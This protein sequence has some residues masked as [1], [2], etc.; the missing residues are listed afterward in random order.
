MEIIKD[1]IKS[2]IF[3]D[4]EC[5]IIILPEITKVLKGVLERSQTMTLRRN[6]S[7]SSSTE[8][9]KLLV[10]C[11]STLGEVLDALYKVSSGNQ[12]EDTENPGKVTV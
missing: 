7:T 9:R 6:G 10:M 3:E 12:K 4:R 2:P 8:S 1:L 11:T 5:R